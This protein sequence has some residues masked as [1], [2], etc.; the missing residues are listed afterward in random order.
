[1]FGAEPDPRPGSRPA[2][3]GLIPKRSGATPIGGYSAST[4]PSAHD[5]NRPPVYDKA[6]ATNA[7]FLPLFEELLFEL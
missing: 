6:N 1:M 7:S 2:R 4:S 5:N 3:S